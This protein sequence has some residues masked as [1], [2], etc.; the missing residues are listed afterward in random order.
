MS[1]RIIFKATN[2]RTGEV[3]GITD[4]YWF[5][6]E[7]V[8]DMEG[9]GVHASYDLQ[10]VWNEQFY[11]QSQMD[12]VTRRLQQMEREYADLKRAYAAYRRGISS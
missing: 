10:F 6:E 7:G 4:L 9:N 3:I 5:E 1:D 2:R 8:R 11:T 12:A